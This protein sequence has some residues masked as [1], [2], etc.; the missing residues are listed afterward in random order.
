MLNQLGWINVCDHNCRSKWITIE[1]FHHL[2][3]KHSSDQSGNPDKNDNGGQNI[4]ENNK[5]ISQGVSG[6]IAKVGRISVRKVGHHRVN[7]EGGCEV[8]RDD[9]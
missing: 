6:L 7:M 8:P 9:K 2:R 1:I 3:K 4:K 5:D